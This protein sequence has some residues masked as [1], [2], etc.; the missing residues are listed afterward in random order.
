MVCARSEAV[1]Q[2]SGIRAFVGVVTTSDDT[3]VDEPAPSGISSVAAVA[4]SKQWLAESSILWG[5][6]DVLACGDAPTT[7]ETGNTGKCPA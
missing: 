6:F 1:W 4:C 5:E 2:A 3:M 7:L